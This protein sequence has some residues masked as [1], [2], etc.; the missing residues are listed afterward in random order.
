MVG[1]RDFLMGS[2]LMT[3]CNARAIEDPCTLVFG[4]QR[5]VLSHGD[6]LCITDTEY[7]AFR[8]L[9]R[10]SQWQQDFLNKP[11]R[12]RQEIAC[13]IRSQSES[14]KSSS[15]PYA[16]VDGQ[17]A[18]TL[19]EGLCADILIH[20]HTHRPGQVKLA[21]GKSRLV[22]SDWVASASPPR[23]DVLRLEASGQ[24]GFT[25]SRI[26]GAAIANELG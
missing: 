7:Q 26:S 5:L 10:S 20:G 18:L 25:L 22:L 23:A 14:R 2:S 1:N 17:A 9:V 13:S 4:N 8:K 16:D 24:S 21:D 12:E 15:A 11:L 3:E 6:A 19:L